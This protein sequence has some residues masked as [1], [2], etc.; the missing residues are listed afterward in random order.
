MPSL[1]DQSPVRYWRSLDELA[2]TPEFR[3]AV[4]REFPNDEWDRLP[5][6]TRRRF[7]QVMGASLGLAGLTACRWPAEEIVPFAHRP[8]ERVPGA[9]QQFATAMELAGAA[10]GMVVTSYDGRPIKAEG[11]PLHPDSLGG[12]SAVAQATILGL[13]DPDRSRRLLMRE[14]GQEYVKTW[15]DFAAVARERFVQGSGR[16]IAVLSEASSSPTFA[17]VRT[18]FLEA[19]P[20]AGWYEHEPD[21]RD[22]GREGSRIAFGRPLRAIPHL[23]R[24]RV[25]ACLDADP[26]LDH[27][28][29]V[30]LAREFAASRAPHAGGTSRLYVAES[31]YTLT[32]GRADHR[33]AVAAGQI[34]RL[35]AALAWRLADRYGVELPGTVADA[36]GEAAAE[37]EF[38]DLLAAD[39]VGYRGAGVILVGHRQPAEVHALA[40]VLNGALGNVG[41]GVTYVAEPDPDRRSHADAITELTARMRA[42]EVETLLVLGGNPVYTTPADLGFADLLA[43]VPF[44]IHLSIHDDETSR[45][46]TWHL[47]VAHH[48]EAWGDGRAW[49]GTWTLQQPLI[50]PLY[51]GR[52]AIELLGMIVR[53][54]AASGYEMVRDSARSLIGR[55]FA[56]EWRRWL[57]DGVV[58]GTASPEVRPAI[59]PAGVERAMA[60]LGELLRTQPPSADRIEL[61]IA[62]DPKVVDGRFANN[63]WL[64]ELPDAVTKITWDNALLM[65]PATARAL[66]VADGDVVGVGAGGAEVDLPVY[67][68][69]GCAPY[70]CTV[71]MG[72]GRTAAGLVGDGVGVDVSPLRTAR[73]PYR[74]EGATVRRTGRRYRLATTQDH[75]AIDTL[76]FAERNLRVANLVREAPLDAFLA[77]PELFHRTD[78]HPPLVQLWK[79]HAYEGE[80]WGMAIDLNACIGCNA[81]VVACQAENNIPLVGREQV[82]NQR[83]MQWIRVD[84]YFRSDPRLGPDQADDAAMVFQPVACVH[85]ENAPCEQVCPVA[86]TQHTSD[87]L[88]AMAYNRCIGTRYCSNNCPYKVRRFNFFNYHKG[89]SEITSMQFNPEVTVRSRGVMEK[90]TYCVQRIQNVRIRARNER[91]PIA[92]GEIVPACAQS[93]PTRAIHFGNLNDP[94][95]EVSKLRAD[96]R[97]YATLPELNIRPRT[98]YLARLSNPAGGEAAPGPAH[99]PGRQGK[100]SA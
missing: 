11:N 56:T 80:Q 31:G 12:L 74:I 30:R 70:S 93:C 41:A 94:E 3:E 36:V 21:S 63:G 5:P 95:S 72:Y 39:L 68:L 18:A 85:C 43:G 64:Q 42:R 4:R 46:C 96:H 10:L 79:E 59:D 58:V 73:S 51:G 19:F 26:L 92:D 22:A 13:Y 17:R 81:C 69:S 52:S 20:G 28:S 87:G 14:A 100:E 77:D 35:L 53:G 32:G 67:L 78:H 65:S 38:L 57:H 25:I 23:D 40:A 47:P 76:G 88:N 15:D 33:L 90:C 91:R 44:S 29:A 1:T 16:G 7:L 24:A 34:P 61:V 48:L 8:E 86:A 9:P 2:R 84:R 60:G 89:L 54:Q 99:E 55:E 71:T 98:H 62:A 66:G 83:E 6:S 49:D 27:P 82:L 45:R 37:G 50:E 97:S 75:H